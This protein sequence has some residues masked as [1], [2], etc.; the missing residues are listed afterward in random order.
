MATCVRCGSTAALIDCEPASVPRSQGR[1]CRC[2]RWRYALPGMRPRLLSLVVSPQA[3]LAASASGPP[4]RRTASATGRPGKTL[5]PSD[6]RA[7]KSM[8][9]FAVWTRPPSPYM[10]Q[11]PGD[12]SPDR[13]GS[14]GACPPWDSHRCGALSKAWAQCG[15]S[16]RG[17]DRR[18]SPFAS[19]ANGEPR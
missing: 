11:C 2:G 9:I 17:D 16:E 7:C 18:G 6:S 15:D 3:S 19:L 10:H 4:A 8:R 12:H 13:A 5:G 1:G 14:P